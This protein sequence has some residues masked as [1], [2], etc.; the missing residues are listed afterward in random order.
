MEAPQALSG[1]EFVEGV[2]PF[3]KIFGFF[4]LGMVYFACILIG[5]WALAVHNASINKVKACKKLRYRR[6]TVQSRY[7]TKN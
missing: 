1:V 5:H 6:Q 7:H 3:Q 2:S 4:C